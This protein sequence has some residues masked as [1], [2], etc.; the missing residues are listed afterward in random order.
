MYL[1]CGYNNFLEHI[2]N[3]TDIDIPGFVI[4]NHPEEHSF[5]YSPRFPKLKYNK[6][7]YCQML[8]NIDIK[9]PDVVDNSW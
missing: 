8:L 4:K 1:L 9:S 6:I 2:L 3:K 5:S 7:Y